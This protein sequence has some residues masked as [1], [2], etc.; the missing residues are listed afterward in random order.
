ME[1][2]RAA[3]IHGYEHALDMSEKMLGHAS[4]ME[5]QE[6]IELEHVYLCEIDQLRDLDGQ[7]A[8][9]DDRRVYKRKILERM[10]SNGDQLRQLLQLKLAEL[11]QL[12]DKNRM[13]QQVSRA[14]GEVSHLLR[15]S[16]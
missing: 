14:Y 10:L 16:P 13:Q 4:A 15:R 9:D 12:I 7:V 2:K 6:L 3:I 5:W 1:T 8:L 11:S